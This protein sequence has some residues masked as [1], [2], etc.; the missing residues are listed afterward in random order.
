MGI[1]PI[2]RVFTPMGGDAGQESLAQLV[3]AIRELNGIGLLGRGRELKLRR[4]VGRR[5]VVDVLDQ[6]TG[7]ALDEIPPEE[8]LRMMAELEKEREEDL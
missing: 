8:V 5:P 1:G 7:E 3:A 4:G 2:N 6:E